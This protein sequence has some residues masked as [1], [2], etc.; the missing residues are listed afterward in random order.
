MSTKAVFEQRR[1]LTSGS[2]ESTG[3]ISQSSVSPNRQGEPPSLGPLTRIPQK[4]TGHCMP[5]RVIRAQGGLVISFQ[6][7]SLFWRR[8]QQRLGVSQLSSSFNPALPAAPRTSQE[9]LHKNFQI[10]KTGLSM[11]SGKCG[12]QPN[13]GSAI[14]KS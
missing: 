7:K 11:C 1:F 8:A 6:D 5:G 3:D 4:S 9:V 2:K 12:L 13:V 10:N 14:S